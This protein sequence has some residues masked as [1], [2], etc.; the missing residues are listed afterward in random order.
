MEGKALAWWMANKNKYSSWAEIETGI[1]LYYGDHY[2][3][4]GVHLEIHELRQTSP[5]QDYLDEI[6]RL[7]T[8][9]KIPDRA[10]INR[11]INKLTGP[12]CRS[13]AHIEHLRENPDEWRMQLLRMDIITTEFQ[14]R[15]KHPRQDDNTDRG[16]KR[17]FEDRIQ[18]KAGTEEKEKSSGSKRDFVPQDQI[19]RRKKESRCFRCGRKNHQPSA[20]EYGGVSQAPPLKYASNPNQVPVNKKPR[21]DEGHLRITELGSEEDS[22]NA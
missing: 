11:I 22:G 19:D 15:D 8:Y 7:N 17:T 1:Q 14:R 18:L 21:T 4:D 3:T 13:M 5:V 20:C 6:E 12:L 10:M 16:K 2:R 9:A